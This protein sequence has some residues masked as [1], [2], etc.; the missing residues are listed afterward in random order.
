M[1]STTHA[2]VS[3]ASSSGR[4]PASAASS[5]GEAADK[6][7]EERFGG[8]WRIVYLKEGYQVAVRIE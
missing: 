5:S 6:W 2:A 3:T 1:I 8:R 7:A 4:G